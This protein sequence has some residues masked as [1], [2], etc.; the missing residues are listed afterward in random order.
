[1]LEWAFGT[2]LTQLGTPTSHQVQV[3]V[4][5]LLTQLPANAVD[6][7]SST[8]VPKTCTGDP[9]GALDSYLVLAQLQPLMGI[10]GVNQ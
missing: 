5:A 10:W 7:S 6:G 8:W 4:P 1:M 9:N 3:L 2:A